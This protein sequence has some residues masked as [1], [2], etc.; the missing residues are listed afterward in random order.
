MAWHGLAWIQPVN[1]SAPWLPYA[2]RSF[3]GIFAMLHPAAWCLFA[4]SLLVALAAFAA[5][6]PALMLVVLVLPLAA[7][8]AWRGARLPALLT[9][10]G[11]VAA[12]VLSPLPLFSQQHLRPF[13]LLAAAGAVLLVL[14]L[15]HR[16]RLP[17]SRPPH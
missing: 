7:L 3:P 11:C 16:P 13:L 2:C 4:L 17:S 9:G 5:F 14:A 12:L 6:T 15:L 8:L 1:C 10:S